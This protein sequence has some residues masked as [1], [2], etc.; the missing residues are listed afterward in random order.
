MESEFWVKCPNIHKSSVLCMQS[1]KLYLAMV[2]F[3]VSPLS[4]IGA[5]CKMYASTLLTG[6]LRS[7]AAIAPVH[8]PVPGRGIPTK[9]AKASACTETSYTG[10]GIL[11]H[12]N[13]AHHTLVDLRHQILSQ[14][15]KPAVKFALKLS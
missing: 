2:K 13:W 5:K 4:S 10:S 8:A 1:A 7:E 6:M 9:S 11:Q 3:G 14:L 15:L 12:L